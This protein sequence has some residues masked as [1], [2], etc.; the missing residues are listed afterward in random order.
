[1]V[2]MATTACAGGAVR[3]P[4]RQTVVRRRAASGSAAASG[5]AAWVRKQQGAA[6]GLLAVGTVCLGVLSGTPPALAEAGARLPPVDLTNK[7]RCQRAFI[8]NTIGQANAVSDTVL[9]LRECDLHGAN[10]EDKVLSGGLLSDSNFSGANMKGAQLTKG[11]A[12]GS[13]FS[14]VDFTNGIVDRVAFDKCNLKGANFS[15]AVLSG[16]T[17]SGADLTDVKWDDV[18]I[19]DQDVKKVCTNESLVGLSRATLGCPRVPAPKK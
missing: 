4:P 9:D 1:M 13:D 16:S 11:Y 17:F 6:V 3:V 7:N 2:A 15:N 8:G 18:I 5:P 14:G 12:I 19:S 10:L